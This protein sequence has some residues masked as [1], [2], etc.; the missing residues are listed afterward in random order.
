MARLYQTTNSGIYTKGLFIGTLLGI[1]LG[2][3]IQR[4][5]KIAKEKKTE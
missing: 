5:Y 3:I 4:K 2:I 1:A